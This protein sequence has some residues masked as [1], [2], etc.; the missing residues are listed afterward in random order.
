[1]GLCAGDGPKRVRVG[2]G[3]GCSLTERGVERDPEDTPVN[4]GIKEGDKPLDV[5]RG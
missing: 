5:W 2:E 4:R 3:E 1:M